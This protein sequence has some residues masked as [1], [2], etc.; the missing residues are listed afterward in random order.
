[1]LRRNRVRSPCQHK[2][3]FTRVAVGAES[4]GVQE[5][6]GRRAAKAPRVGFRHASAD[7]RPGVLRASPGRPIATARSLRAARVTL[8]AGRALPHHRW[9]HKFSTDLTGRSTPAGVFARGVQSSLSESASSGYGQETLGARRIYHRWELRP[10]AVP[11]S[12]PIAAGPR[13]RAVES[14]GRGD[15]PRARATGGRDGVRV[16]G[17]W[18]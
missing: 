13:R 18:Q 7:L 16:L 9:S 1:L 10:P 14:A 4:T 8:Q 12:R 11:P 5:F 17:P 6:C 2:R 3:T 15:A